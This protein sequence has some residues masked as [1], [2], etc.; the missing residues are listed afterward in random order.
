MTAPARRQSIETRSL[1]HG[2]PIPAASRIGPLVASSVIAPRDPVT[3]AIPPELSEQL[4]HLFFHVG[5]LLEAA[6]G[7]WRHVLK[8]D[9]YSG[10]TRAREVINEPWTRFFPDEASRPARHTHISPDATG[11]ITCDF[12]AYIDG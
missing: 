9:F 11:F 1:Q 8:M 6:G 3:G 10:D 2:N 4:E 7:D 5:S 12:L